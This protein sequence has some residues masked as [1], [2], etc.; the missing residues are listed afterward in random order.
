MILGAAR[1]ATASF[2]DFPAS[3]LRGRRD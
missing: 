1:A 3:S 2:I